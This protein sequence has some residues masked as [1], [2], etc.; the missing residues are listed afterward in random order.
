[1]G[2]VRTSIPLACVAT[3]LGAAPAPAAAQEDGARQI[4]AGLFIG[5]DLVTSDVE[6]GNSY[7]PDQVPGSGFLVGARGGMLLASLA[8]HTAMSPRIGVE[9]ETK[10]AFSSTDAEGERDSYFA[11]IIGWRVH[12]LLD[13]YSDSRLAP[14]VLAGLGGQTVLT[15]SPFV[16]SGD[17]DA[18]L[19][20]GAGVRWR[21]SRGRRSAI[22]VDLRHVLSAGRENLTSSSLEL[23]VGFGVT[24]GLGDGEPRIGKKIIAEQPLPPPDPAPDPD[25]VI[26]KP[27]PPPDPPPPPPDDDGDGVAGAAD[28]C[29]DDPEDADGHEDGDGCPD[30][31]NDG[32]GIADILDRCPDAAE[33]ANGFDD[34]DGCADE[35]PP[36]VA[37]F[38]GVVAGIQFAGGSARLV[39]GART[40]LAKAAGVLKKYPD[41]RIKIAGYTDNQGRDMANLELSAKRAIAVK[42][43]L[44]QQGI[45]AARIETVGLGSDSPIAD[46]GT[47]AGRQQNRRIEFTLLPPKPSP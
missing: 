13:T 43:Y 8:P 44:V 9:L 45:A 42:T 20:W 28:G 22:R 46:N 31:D 7:Y 39:P 32:D 18:A 14:F 5:G 47:A 40:L 35:V 30:L 6:L 12:A 3:L 29:P 15:S 11:P 24:F 36:A 26:V 33:T 1:M 27:Q 16:A 19:H 38:T 4:T 10:L 23:H 37:E 34:A 17:T 41:L 25:D 2:A 21:V